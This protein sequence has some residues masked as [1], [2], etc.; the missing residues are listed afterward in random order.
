MKTYLLRLKHRQH[1]LVILAKITAAE[2]QQGREAGDVTSIAGLDIVA[3]HLMTYIVIPSQ[4]DKLTRPLTR[5]LPR[6]AGH[7]FA[8]CLMQPLGQA[9]PEVY[10]QL[11]LTAPAQ[12]G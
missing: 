9:L 10:I 3:M 11:G 7:G 6:G 5:V 2:R 12:I 8:Q 1:F 4:K